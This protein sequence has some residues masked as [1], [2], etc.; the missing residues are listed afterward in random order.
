MNPAGMNGVCT[1]CRPITAACDP[2][3]TPL[4]DLMLA[5]DKLLVELKI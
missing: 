1:A 3:L 4:M 5:M 2:M